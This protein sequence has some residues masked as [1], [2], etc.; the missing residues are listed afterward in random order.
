MSEAQAL[1]V[2]ERTIHRQ[3]LPRAAVA[4]VADHGVIDG[5]EVDPDLVGAAGLEPAPSSDTSTGSWYSPRTS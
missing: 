5:R 1:G 4:I 3:R 2:Q